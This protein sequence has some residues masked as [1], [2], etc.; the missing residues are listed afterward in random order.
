MCTAKGATPSPATT[1]TTTTAVTWNKPTPEGQ[2]DFLLQQETVP[3]PRADVPLSWFLYSLLYQD[4]LSG[5]VK[6]G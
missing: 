2:S 4:K 6:C 5:K 3:Q 1:T